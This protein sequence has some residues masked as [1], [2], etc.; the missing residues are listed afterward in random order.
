MIGGFDRASA[1]RA[2]KWSEQHGVSRCSARPAPSA[3]RMPKKNAVVLGDRVERQIAMRGAELA[4]RSVSTAAFVAATADDEAAGKASAVTLL[5]AVSCNIPLAEAGH[6]RFPIDAWK[7]KGAK[8][9]VVA[10]DAFC[11]RDVLKDLGARAVSEPVA[12]TLESSV[13]ITELPRGIT[14]LSTAAGIVP[15]L[16]AKPNEVADPDVR[17]FMENLGVRPSWWTA[18]GH[19]A[20]A[21]AK[22]AVAKL[23]HDTTTD[24]HAI[25]QRRAQ[26]QAGLFA[27]KVKLWTTDEQ[28]VATSRVLERTLEARDRR[29]GQALT[30][31]ADASS[32]VRHEL[33]SDPLARESA[34][35]AGADPG[36][37]A[38]A[39]A[40]RNT[41]PR[42][43]T[44]A[45]KRRDAGLEE[46][47]M[48]PMFGKT[49]HVE[50]T[51][52]DLFIEHYDPPVV[53]P[54]TSAAMKGDPRKRREAGK[55]RAL[56]RRKIPHPASLLGLLL[57]GGLIT[58]AGVV[59]YR[60]WFA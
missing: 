11:A 40:S 21:L 58:G 55:T 29:A 17:A 8:S 41:P 15:V 57:L 7:S 12:L 54:K 24:P 25:A 20:G 10:G 36:S 27:T 35:A 51:I 34:P 42:S 48:N 45:A 2:V 13:P 28:G 1:D 33:S 49:D 26:V 18:L 30:A 46:P 59:G 9:V 23:P 4:R 37:R 16:A 5:P 56:S 22:A 43:G 38:A 6:T 14:M 32:R 47:P 3:D 53:P 39:W 44:S 50:V 19:D 31:R 52:D 60:R